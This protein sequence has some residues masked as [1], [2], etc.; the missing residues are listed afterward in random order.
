MNRKAK[1]AARQRGYR[2][3]RAEQMRS[4]SRAYRQRNL[5]EI[6]AKERERKRGIRLLLQA[7]Q[8]AA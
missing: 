7:G 5:E 2:K 6:R 4:Y 8:D 3:D 1:A